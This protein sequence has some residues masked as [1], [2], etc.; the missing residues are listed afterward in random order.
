M[1]YCRHLSHTSQSG[2]VLTSA[3]RRQWAGIAQLLTCLP[4]GGLF[5]IRLESLSSDR[6][7]GPAYFLFP[8]REKIDRGVKLTTHRHLDQGQGPWFFK[9]WMCGLREWLPTNYWHW[10]TILMS[11][12]ISITL[13]IINY[14]KIPLKFNGESFLSYLQLSPLT[15]LIFISYL[16]HAFISFPP[17]SVNV[18]KPS[19][20]LNI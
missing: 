19:V 12:D 6:P 11:E 20:H 16:C 9:K 1:V 17:F 3:C 18:F 7:Q 15:Y 10:L 5:T 13:S 14:W 2:L 4:T 8:P